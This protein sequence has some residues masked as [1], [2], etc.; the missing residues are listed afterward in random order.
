MELKTT[1]LAV[2]GAVLL[3]ISQGENIRSSSAK[4]QKISD[5]K[6]IHK[7]YIKSEK[8]RARNAGDLSKVALGRYKANC[9]MVVDGDSK[10]ESYFQPGAG[11]VDTALGKP[12][13]EG[14]FICNRLG[15]TA[16][17]VNGTIENIAS[18]SA[19]DLAE[20]IAILERRGYRPYKPQAPQK[21]QE[22]EKT[23][24]V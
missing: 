11:V 16:I 12:L 1:H 17:V 13:R 2:I 9:I 8:E 7:D 3:L 18:I 5:R 24:D 23:N 6:T 19:E 22:K 15:D 10:K 14:A 21:Q 4:T 20:F